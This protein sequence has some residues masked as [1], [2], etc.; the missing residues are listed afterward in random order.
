MDKILKKYSHIIKGWDYETGI[1][2]NPN[3]TYYSVWLKKPY[4][5]EYDGRITDGTAFEK[6]K[7][8]RKYL[9]SVRKDEQA[10][11]NI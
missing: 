4:V 6:I 5:M 9:K 10:W 8:I 11:N 2:D 3:E 7:D 1:G